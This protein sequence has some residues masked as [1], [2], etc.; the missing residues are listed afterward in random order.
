MHCNAK[1]IG[2][3]LKTAREAKGMTQA[4]LCKGAQIAQRT[5][6]DIEN[7]K[8]RPTFDVFD[9]I[10]HAL[11][12]SADHVFWPERTPYT[13]EHEQLIRA[14]AACSERD[15]AVFMEMA[16]AFVRALEYADNSKSV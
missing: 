15:K 6:I 11:D 4:A 13:P 16:W 12:L 14:I 8:R 10:I 7:G 1:K 3:I 2:E 9:K 5:I